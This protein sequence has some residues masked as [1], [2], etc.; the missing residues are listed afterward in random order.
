MI[1]HMSLYPI[2]YYCWVVCIVIRAHTHHP[3]VICNIYTTMDWSALV[4]TMCVQLLGYLIILALHCHIQYKY[5]IPYTVCMA[6]FLQHRVLT[7]AVQ[8][9][10]LLLWAILKGAGAMRACRDMYSFKYTRFLVMLPKFNIY[11][12]HGTAGTSSR[13]ANF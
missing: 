11:R 5:P 7:H 12:I 10:I 1:L 13:W 2:P 4:C 6:Q 9:Q 3:T 8:K